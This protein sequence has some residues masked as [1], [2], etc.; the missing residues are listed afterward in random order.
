MI[1][2]TVKKT[3]LPIGLLSGAAGLSVWV[4]LTTVVINFRAAIAQSPLIVLSRDIVRGQSITASGTTA[5]S[6]NLTQ[7][8]VRDRHR[9]LCLGYGS[10]QP[11]HRLELSEDQPRLQIA[12]NSEGQDTTLLIHG[13]WGIDCNDNQGRGRRD[14]AINARNWPAGLYQIWVGSFDAGDRLDYVLEI[15]DPT[16]NRED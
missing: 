2:Q 3:F 15:S 4:S 6:Y 10:D 16:A 8:A 7:L 13:P 9:K 1:R 14:A 12:I 11:S 5:G